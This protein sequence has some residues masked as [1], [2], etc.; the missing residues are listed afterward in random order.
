[1]TSALRLAAAMI[2]LAAPALA[3]GFE[4]SA[5]LAGLQFAQSIGAFAPRFVPAPAVLAAAAPLPD[6]ASLFD[7]GTAPTQKELEGWRAGRRFTKDGPAPALLVGKDVYH[8]PEDGPIS[9]KDFKVFAFG[10][11]TAGAA[12]VDLYDDPGSELQNAINYYL[13]EDAKRWSAAEFREKG[14]LTRKDAQP[15]IEIRRSGEWLVARYADGSY[16][17]FFK[18][19]RK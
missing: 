3:G 18:K 2:P 8:K 10:P 4:K 6:L 15:P 1:M 16:G 17:Y 19:V 12:P 11:D 13:R 5:S 14:A 9:G 7:K